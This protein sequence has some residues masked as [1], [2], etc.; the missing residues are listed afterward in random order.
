MDA[1]PPPVIRLLREP[2]VHGFVDLMRTEKQSLG[3]ST[4]ASVIRAVG[5]DAAAQ[6][7][8]LIVVAALGDQIVGAMVVLLGGTVPYWRS[9]PI[10]HPVA[11]ARVLLRRA[12]KVLR[13]RLPRR[14]KAPVGPPREP[15][16]GAPEGD[17]PN[18]LVDDPRLHVP[19]PQLPGSPHLREAGPHVAFGPM[20]VVSAGSRKLGLA[21]Q[22]HA[23]A[24]DELRRRGVRRYNNSFLL[25]YEPSI[26]LYLSLGFTIYRLPFG[27]LGTYDLDAD[28]VMEPQ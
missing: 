27:Y 16:V 28:P 22:M 9:F 19:P 26:R 2:D 17:L 7:R 23:V 14:R 6:R 1:S 20:V 3:G 10:R 18:E 11:G 25:D 15:S 4:D 21:K 8:A 24:F 13:A 12:R 5:H